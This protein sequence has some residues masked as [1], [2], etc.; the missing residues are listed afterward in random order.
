M[1]GFRPAPQRAPPAPKQVVQATDD[2][3][4]ES[5]TESDVE[6]A[7]EEGRPI[8]YST[9]HSIA[10]KKDFETAKQC[11]VFVEALHPDKNHSTFTE[12]LS[13]R[14]IPNRFKVKALV[15][16]LI[17]GPVSNVIIKWCRTCDRR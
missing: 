5:E 13:C 11:P 15:S 4:A 6:R 7:E 8:K 3:A 10:D 14:T 12:M 9:V 16:S 17:P 2:K 1:A